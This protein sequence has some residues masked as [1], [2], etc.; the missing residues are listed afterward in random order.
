[1]TPPRKS[2]K[3]QHS[4]DLIQDL[5]YQLGST[6]TEYLNIKMSFRHS[7]F[8]KLHP[9]PSRTGL[10]RTYTTIQT[11][12]AATIK[13][14][15]TSSPW[16]PRPAPQSN[17]LFS[18]I[19]AN[20]GADAANDVMYRIFASRST[21]RKAANMA[22]AL[23]SGRTDPQKDG[24][25]TKSASILAAPVVP[26]RRASLRRRHAAAAETISAPVRG[27]SS[28]GSSSSDS[29]SDQGPDPARKIWTEMRKLS[30]GKNY[31]YRLRQSESEL[32][33]TSPRKAIDFGLR[34]TSGKG[35]DPVGIENVRE[36]SISGDWFPG[37]AGTERK[38]S[39]G[40]G[41]LKALVG[42]NTESRIEGGRR[43]IPGSRVVSREKV[44]GENRK[45]EKETGRWGWVSWW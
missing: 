36:P 35:S 15:N 22:R 23:D 24:A 28:S 9:S 3:K 21:P 40:M 12:A 32:A 38:T 31:G 34:N 1:M 45:K 6:T 13:R 2:H 20:W 26:R 17:S 8:P 14:H 41:A 27:S 44:S 18:V 16:S 10:S 25:S 5:E 43:Q 4:E 37:R 33:P 42:A 11:C 39:A 29:D 19:A 30:M 7:A